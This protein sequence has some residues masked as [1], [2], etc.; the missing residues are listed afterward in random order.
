MIY[1]V[2]L[3]DPA[4]LITIEAD[5]YYSDGGLINF[6]SGGSNSYDDGA[7]RV[8]SF[9]IG[10]IVFVTNDSNVTSHRVYPNPTMLEPPIRTD[11]QREQDREILR[12][13]PAILSQNPSAGRAGVPTS[14]YTNQ[15]ATYPEPP[16]ATA[17]TGT[18]GRVYTDQD[19]S[20]YPSITGESSL[21]QEAAD[22]FATRLDNAVYSRMALLHA[23]SAT[24]ARGN[25]WNS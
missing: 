25:E 2:A 12:H 15:T 13:A 3:R 6:T 24:C 5:N 16:R 8:G 7:A 18:F 19:A 11:E 17:P 20:S 14:P 9:P 23:D 4:R 1:T 22:S 21:R 10:Q